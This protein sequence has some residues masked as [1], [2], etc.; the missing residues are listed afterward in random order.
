[1]QRFRGRNARFAARRGPRD[2]NHGG[3]EQALKRCGASVIDLHAIGNGC[4]DLLVGF[5]GATFLLEV[6]MPKATL[7]DSQATFDRDWKGYPIHVVRNE[8]EAL[9]AIGVRIDT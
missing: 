6:K 4:P 1:M 7:E 9:V 3:I 5:R 2:A 8:A